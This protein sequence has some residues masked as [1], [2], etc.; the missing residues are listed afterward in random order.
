[1]WSQYQVESIS[2]NLSIKCFFTI[3]IF[4]GWIFQNAKIDPFALNYNAI[5][6]VVAFSA[7]THPFSITAYSAPCCPSVK[8]ALHPQQ[9]CGFSQSHHNH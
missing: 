6:D 1:M 8:A 4:K 2:W 3:E 9:V 5:S 7:S